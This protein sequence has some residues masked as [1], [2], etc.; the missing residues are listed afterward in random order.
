MKRSLGDYEVHKIK[1]VATSFAM[2][3]SLLAVTQAANATVITT[4]VIEVLTPATGRGGFAFL[5]DGISVTGHHDE[6]YRWLS[7][8]DAGTVFDGSQF[9]SVGAIE[10][11]DGYIDSQPV[12][13]NS[14]VPGGNPI[15]TRWSTTVPGALLTAGQTTYTSSFD[16][17]G[18]LCGVIHYN[19]ACDAIFPSLT[20]GGIAEFF[21]SESVRGDGTHYFTPTKATYTFTAIPEPATLA[22]FCV[23]LAGLVF[24]R[25]RQRF[26]RT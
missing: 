17:E 26:F 16:F 22:L 6:G 23:G 18:S 14:H 7:P 19:T 5:I 9:I 20:G 25:R 13:W 24:T 11:F 8:F 15:S 12:L 3:L 4:G 2:L 21:F 10:F 1:T